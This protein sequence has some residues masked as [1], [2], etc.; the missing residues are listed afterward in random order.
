MSNGT[1]RS[2]LRCLHLILSIPIIG[3]VYS[4]F[5]E[6]PNY[7]PIVRFV[8]V[9]VLILSGFWMYAGVVVAVVAVTV[10]LSVNY[11]CGY[12]VAILS[13]IVLF[14]AWKIWLALRSRQAPRAA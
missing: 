13:E 3:Y 1:K 7:A 8:S 9:P 10:W 4:P 2:I 6:L 5:A 14:I 11:F 12:G